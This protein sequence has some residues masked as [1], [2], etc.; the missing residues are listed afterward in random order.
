[1]FVVQDM[2]KSF[3]LSVFANGVLLF[4]LLVMTILYF[5]KNISYEENPGLQDIVTDEVAIDFENNIYAYHVVVDETVKDINVLAVPYTKDSVITVTGADNMKT[6][7]NQITIKVE[8]KKQLTKYYYIIVE[9]TDI[10]GD[11]S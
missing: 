7:Y 4:L 6:G 11:Q 5:T 8:G 2:K 9:K 10:I 3:T 1:M